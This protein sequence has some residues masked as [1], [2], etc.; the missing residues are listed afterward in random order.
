[1][2]S[3]PLNIISLCY[4][5]IDLS[6]PLCILAYP[7]HIPIYIIPFHSTPPILY[8]PIPILFLSYTYPIHIPISVLTYAYPILIVLHPFL[9]FAS[10][11]LSY[12]SYPYPIISLYY[13]Y[14]I[15]HHNPI[16]FLCYP[17]KML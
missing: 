3:Y 8:R 12:P 16:L 10:P 14:P 17:I 13:T 6:H 7:N 1:M 11:L 15:S 4:P 9:C 2:L 5:Y